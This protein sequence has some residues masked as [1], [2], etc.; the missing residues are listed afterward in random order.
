MTW[1]SRRAVQRDV[2]EV[3]IPG[4]D[5]ASGLV[6]ELHGQWHT[7]GGRAGREARRWRGCCDSD[8]QTLAVGAATATYRQRHRVTPR[9]VIRV[10]RALRRTVRRTIAKVPIPAR[11]AAAR[12]VR[13]LHRQG[14]IARG[15]VGREA[16]RWRG[17][18]YVDRQALAVGAAAG[19]Y[20]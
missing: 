15:R 12:L 6:G 14:R 16:R 1:T 19:T 3:P 17:R 20:R 9:S 5:R 4:R 18:C 8:R 2:P 10:R 7:A 13:A 11:D